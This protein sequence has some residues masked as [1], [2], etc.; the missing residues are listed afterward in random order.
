MEKPKTVDI[1]LLQK[2]LGDLDSPN[3]WDLVYATDTLADMGE[4]LAVF[5]VENYE[6]LN[7]PS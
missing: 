3:Y 1:E 5:I 2:L 7:P 6:K 4:D